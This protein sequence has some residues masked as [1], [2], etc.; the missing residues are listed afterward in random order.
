M[1]W[2]S[3]GNN[4]GFMAYG[5]NGNP[6]VRA[7]V[8]D[9]EF[10]PT[11]DGNVEVIGLTLDARTRRHA[12]IDATLCAAA[13]EGRDDVVQRLLAAGADVHAKNDLALCWATLMGH[14]DMTRHL[15]AAG[16]N[17]HARS[18]VALCNAAGRGNIEVIRMLLAAAADV[19]VADEEP[20]RAAALKGHTTA[21]GLLLAAGADPLAGWIATR[22]SDRKRLV[23]TLDA[24]VDA[25]TLGQC[26]A[27]V[28]V[29]SGFSG[30]R[31]RL[32]SVN[33]RRHLGR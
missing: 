2:R 17:V 26:A 13:A 30:V 7:A 12:R 1:A 3:I 24:C 32:G 31:A 10:A 4:G 23:D 27:L 5:Q 33:Q 18:D 25:L 11:A 6:P 20:L 8:G 28:G 22:P 14:L 15:L 29:S 9:H 19:H 21:V 16:A